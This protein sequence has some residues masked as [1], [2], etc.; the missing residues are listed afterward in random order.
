MFPFFRIFRKISFRKK[1]AAFVSYD[2][3][4]YVIATDNDD[5]KPGT[6]L[7]SVDLSPELKDDLQIFE[8]RR[9]LSNSTN[10]SQV[11]GTEFADS[12]SVNTPAASIQVP[13][14]E[15]IDTF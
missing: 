7:L 1:N 4:N 14:V 9:S 11:A 3:A 10:V 2:T 12:Q 6:S 13:A 5:N 15:V 8:G